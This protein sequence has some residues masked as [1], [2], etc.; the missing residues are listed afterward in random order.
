[1]KKCEL[2]VPAGGQEQLI[3]AVENGADA[4][5]LGGKG[6]NAR[7]NAGNFADEEMKS[8][9]AFC[10]RRGVRVYV[11]MNTL[12]R[13]EEMQQALDYAAFLYE[14]GADALIIQDLGLGM[15][16][17]E[18][19]PD[20][21]LHLST[22]GS[23][24]DLRGTEAAFRMGYSRVVLA[25]ELSFDEIRAVCSGTEAEIEVFVHGAMCIC[26]SGQCQM[27]RYMG[28]RSGN[29]GQCAQPCRLPYRT[30]DADGRLLRTCA[31]PLSPKDL[32]LIDHIGELAE[33]GVASLKIE[34]RMKSAEYVAVVTSIY[35]K[36]L[37]LYYSR[38]RYTVDPQDREALEQ[39]FNR[40]GFTEGYFDGDPGMELMAGDIPKHRGIEIGKVIRRVPGG[41]LIDVKLYHEL[42]I[43]DGV[44]IHGENVT[45]NVVTYCRELKNG[46]TRIGDIR[47]SV[48]RGDRL[49]RLTSKEQLAAARLS[50][51]GKTF[52][53]GKYIRKTPLDAAFSCSRDGYL[54]LELSSPLLREP[55]SIVEGPFSLEE[56]TTEFSRV[57][58]ALR[59]T[60]NTPF[61][62]EKIRCGDDQGR[63]LPVSLINDI[64]RKALHA[65]EEKLDEGREPVSLSA[66]TVTEKPAEGMLE[67]CFYSWEDFASFEMPRELAE[68][69]VSRAALI[70]LTDFEENFGQI[71]PERMVIPYITSVSRG[72]EDRYIE[73]HF[74][75]IVSHVKERGV[76][77]G[78][79]GWIGP[80]RSAGV[81]V[82][83]DF[84]LNICNS[85][86]GS[87]C[88]SLGVRHYVRSLETED[89]GCGA[90]PLMISRHVPEGAWLIDRKKEKFSLFRHKYSDQILLLPAS[91]KIDAGAVLRR[92]SEQGGI[93]RIYLK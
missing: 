55:V 69:D 18:Q 38:G 48:S 20:F 58:K 32:C 8:A 9:I 35:R 51:T 60:G 40:G 27:S 66:Y 52:E 50:F 91:E 28:G 57:E 67:F 90:Y 72:R 92:L 89:G 46:L 61:A 17:R 13:N 59:K 16:L 75:S 83:G 26:C 7:I 93:V 36:Y 19:L 80:L 88:Q 64:R 84:G 68:L 4:V 56:G 14:A 39:I 78:N 53:T 30:L 25:R 2:L 81:P 21:E 54:K 31:H 86:A 43:G 41:Q 33:A 47:G 1:M 79:L 49:F 45:G 24:Y 44:E 10:H 73:E 70:P 77:V 74:E 15:L 63:I 87:A 76:Y 12:I 37:D 23:V 3:A 22:Q 11:T 65:L 85:F 82:Y 71:A 62:V 34:G 5:Y 42:S 6:F 29:R